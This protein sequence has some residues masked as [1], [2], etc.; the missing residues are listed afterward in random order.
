MGKI[1]KIYKPKKQGLVKTI[2]AAGAVLLT[3]CSCITIDRE[4]IKE[5]VPEITKEIKI[6]LMKEFDSTYKRLRNDLYQIV[7]DKIVGIEKRL[8]AKFEYKYLPRLTKALR[9]YQP[10]IQEKE[11]DKIIKY[12]KEHSGFVKNKEE[13]FEWLKK[14][15]VLEKI[16]E[17]TKKAVVR[18]QTKKT[19]S[20]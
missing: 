12:V 1:S 10:T 4:D 16:I 17:E 18:P 8:D 19:L 14:E 3:Y 5:Y 9:D 13:F 7:N 11:I 2:L 15:K 20:K 6:S